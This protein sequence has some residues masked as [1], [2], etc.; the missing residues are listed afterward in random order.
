MPCSINQFNSPK[1][2]MN[3]SDEEDYSELEDNIEEDPEYQVD[4]DEIDGG[5]EGFLKGYAEADD[6]EK[7]SEDEFEHDDE[8]KK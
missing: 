3:M 1:K 2:G 6:F 4:N 7:Q 5:E 8:I